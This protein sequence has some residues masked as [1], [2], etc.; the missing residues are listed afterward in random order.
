[1]YSSS[2]SARPIA[3]ILLSCFAA[4]LVPLTNAATVTYDFNITWVSANPDGLWT[5]PV[6][7]INNQ[8]P[9]PTI[10]ANL[11]DQLIVNVH[12]QLGNESTSLHF[13]GLFQNGTTAMDG[14]VGA[15]QCAIPSGASLAYNFTVSQ[16]V[17][18]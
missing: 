11:G 8:W 10:Y 18:S 9:L 4:S 16:S 5:R 17:H 6:Q 7:G 15:N 13:H 2:P 1:M 3:A 12:N 14:P